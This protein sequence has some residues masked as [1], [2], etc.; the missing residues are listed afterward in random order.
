[1]GD[2]AEELIKVKERVEYLL[3]KYPS[4]RNSDNYLILLYLKF[5]GKWPIPFI[6]WDKLTDINIESVRRVRQKIHNEEH[7]FEPTDPAIRLQRQERAEQYRRDI[8]K[9]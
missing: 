2:I 3:D 4:T 5:F 6:E 8:R 9:V 1:M 7:R